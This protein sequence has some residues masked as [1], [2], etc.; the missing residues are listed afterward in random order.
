MYW[1]D[2]G[3][4]A[5]I[6]RASMDGQARKV[7]VSNNLIWPNGITI[8]YAQDRLY[9]ADANLHKIEYSNLDGS[10]RLLLETALNG[11][12]HPFS[13]TI[14]NEVLYWTELQNVSIFA[15]HKS[16]GQDILVIT[17]G[18][19]FVTPNSIEAVTPTRQ[20]QG[21]SE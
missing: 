18:S 5:M 9:W 21:T 17:P 10:N 11:V 16:N 2:W 4:T 7:I 19:L 6:E 15:T 3:E 20:P 14:E 1:S 12:L 13:I 8:D